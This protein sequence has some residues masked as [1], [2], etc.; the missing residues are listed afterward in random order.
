MATLSAQLKV[1][2]LAMLD[3]GSAAGK[4]AGIPRASASAVIDEQL[5]ADEIDRQLLGLEAKAL[6]HGS[7]LGSGFSYPVTV[8]QV[9]HWAQGIA[10]RGYQL[11]PASAITRK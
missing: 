2:G 5:S 1:R 6:A 9:A 8:D 3:D 7:A 10:S 11:A 4:G